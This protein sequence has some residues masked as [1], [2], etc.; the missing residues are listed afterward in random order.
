[1]L[2]FYTRKVEWGIKKLSESSMIVILSEA[3][4]LAYIGPGTGRGIKALPL[5][6]TI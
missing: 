1:M 6:V 2:A 5:L 4:N 3:K